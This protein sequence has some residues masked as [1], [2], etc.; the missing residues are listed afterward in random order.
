MSG[1]VSGVSVATLTLFY[2]SVTCPPVDGNCTG[3]EGAT[4]PTR[5]A[6]IVLDRVLWCRGFLYHPFSL[7]VSVSR[8]T[9]SST[10]TATAPR[11]TL[12][13]EALDGLYAGQWNLVALGV[14]LAID[15]GEAVFS[16]KQ[17]PAQ[18]QLRQ[19]L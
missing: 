8:K 18:T 11:R 14:N 17:S 7:A 10:R 4:T 5:W 9:R 3:A 6:E 15:H 13:Q 2:R 19:F 1:M 12:C 16:R